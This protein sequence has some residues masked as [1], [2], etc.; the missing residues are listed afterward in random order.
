MTYETDGSVV[1]DGG[2]GDT[3]WNPG[4]ANEGIDGLFV[5]ATYPD[6]MWMAINGKIK[7]VNA[8]TTPQ[9]AQS[10]YTADS[11]ISLTKDN[12][13][14]FKE[15]RGMIYFCNGVENFGRIAVSKLKTQLTTSPADETVNIRAGAYT[16]TISGSGTNE[17]YVSISAVNPQISEPTSLTINAAPA[18]EG[19]VGALTAGQWGYGNTDSLG[20][21]TVYVRLSDGTDPD[22]KTDGYVVANFADEII[23][24]DASGYRFNTEPT[25]AATPSYAADK[26]YIDG[27]EIDYTGIT[28]YGFGDKLFGVTNI[29]TTHEIG[30]YVTQYSAVTSTPTT[31]SIKC[32]TMAFFKETMW[33]AG[34]PDEPN[35]L[36]YGKTVAAVADIATHNIQDFTDG[37]NYL[38]GEGGPITALLSTRDRLYVFQRDRIYY[39]TIV[40][41]DTGAENFSTEYLFSGIHGCPNPFSVCEMGDTVIVFTGKRLIKI[42]YDPETHQL[43]PSEDFDDPIVTLLRAADIDQSNAEVFYNEDD[44]KLRLRFKIDGI[45]KTAVYNNLSKRWSYPYDE[46]ATHYVKHGKT[47]YFGFGDDD[48]IYRSGLTFDADDI[49]LPRRFVSGRI[50]DGNRNSKLFLRGRIE[51]SKRPGN[52]L[53]LTTY[54]DNQPFGGAREINDTHMLSS[55]PG[56]PLGSGAVGTAAIGT[57]G[58]PGE[59]KNYIYP[60]VIGRRGKDIRVV[61]SSD[62]IGSDWTAS[63]GEIEY[64]E[65]SRD[66]R[67]HY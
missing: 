66:P 47:T 62:E 46:D 52:K 13:V 12:N 20:Y 21:N 19:T 43:L 48:I 40:I 57:G 7:Q 10:V 17:Y 35:V 23:L 54:I 27:D 2:Y 29:A 4:E 61:L 63:G 45:Y 56:D 37:N 65:F 49:S 59:R 16:W 60:F 18:T 3:G 6:P 24:E 42:G 33:I 30:A 55:S 64:E 41:D 22:T 44:K 28:G 11:G 39:I 5:M 34:M 25:N 31:G 8:T 32:S 50:D 14:F 15:Y 53:Y 36:R 38:I 58:P 51:G 67:K 26:V 1:C 9:A